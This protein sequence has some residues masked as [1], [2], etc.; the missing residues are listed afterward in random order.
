MVFEDC[1]EAEQDEELVDL[2][3]LCRVT[4]ISCKEIL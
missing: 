4:C 3:M 2:P 1:L